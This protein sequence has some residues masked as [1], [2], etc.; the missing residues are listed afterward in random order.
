MN[1]VPL[2]SLALTHEA[3]QSHYTTC[4]NK[5]EIKT[6]LGCFISSCSDTGAVS[7]TKLL[8]YK[9]CIRFPEFCIFSCPS[10]YSNGWVIGMQR[11]AEL[12]TSYCRTLYTAVWDTSQTI[13]LAYRLPNLYTYQVPEMQ[14][15]EVWLHDCL[16][17]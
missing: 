15:K 14:D 17:P 7:F 6:R 2:L 16:L 1:T 9:T 8:T 10:R 12:P 3:A 13:L 4:C 11:E 5:R